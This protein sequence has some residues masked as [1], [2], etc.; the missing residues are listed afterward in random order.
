MDCYNIKNDDGRR[1]TRCL[2]IGMCS[3]GRG[4]G[5]QT[6]PVALVASS[7]YPWTHVTPG[8]LLPCLEDHRAV[9]TVWIMQLRPEVYK[10]VVSEEWLIV[11]HRSIMAGIASLLAER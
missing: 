9:Q 10:A 8:T 11:S 7:R 6:V 1:E 3:G 2:R 5:D 4:A